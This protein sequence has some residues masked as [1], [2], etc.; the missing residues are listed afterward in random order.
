[1]TL[2]ALKIEVKSLKLED[3]LALADF[4]A[5][6]DKAS[7]AARR[8]RIDRRMKSMDAGRKITQEQLLAVHGAFKSLGL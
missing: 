5:E 6:Q 4:I 2:D 8:A 1:M 7:N 3:R